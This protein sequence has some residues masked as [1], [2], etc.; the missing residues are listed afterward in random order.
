MQKNEIGSLP[1]AIYINYS[2]WF[3][4]PNKRAKTLKYLKENMDKSS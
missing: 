3:K 1:H 4:D 2:R